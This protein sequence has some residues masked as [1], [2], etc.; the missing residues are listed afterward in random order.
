MENNYVIFLVNLLQD[1]NILRPLV[2]MAAHDLRLRTEFMVNRQ[3]LKRD[4]TLSWQRELE[5]MRAETGTSIL[6]VENEM[7]TLA[8][9]QGKAGALIAASESNL[10][11]HS[12]THDIFR[13]AP[14]SFL[15]ITLQHGFECVGFL[16]SKEHTLSYGLDVTF[17]ADVVCS[18]VDR[19][20]LISMTPSQLP[21]VYVTGS[22]GVLQMHKSAGILQNIKKTG[23]V[24]E[25]LH[26][27]R[28]N[29]GGDFKTGFMEIFRDYCATLAGEGQLVT[30]RPHPGGQ[31]MLKSNFELPPNVILNNNPVYKVDLSGYAYGI[32]APSS[33]LIDMVLAGIPVAVWADE[34]GVM[35]T[36]NYRGLTKISTLADWIAFSHDAVSNPGKYLSLQT[37]FLENLRMVTNPE[38]T[39]RQFARL[40]LATSR[41]TRTPDSSIFTPSDRI[42]FIANGMDP[43]LQLCLLNP[44]ESEMESGKL[45][46]SIITGE[47]IST[48]FGT[49]YLDETVQQWID[50]RIS[51]F[52]PTIVVFCR[53]NGRHADYMVNIARRQGMPVIYHL[54]DDLL[55]VP[56]HLGEKKYLKHNDPQRL[57]TV[58]FLLDKSDLVYCSTI[59]LK[60]HFQ[61]AG[62]MTPLVGGLINCAGSIIVPAAERKARRI[63]YMGFDKVHEL[64]RILPAIVKFLRQNPEVEFELFGTFT[65]PPLLE[66]FG[67]RIHLFKPVRDYKQFLA[68]LASHE[69]DIGI[70]PLEVTPFNLK[71]SNNKW[72]EYTSVGIAVIASRSTVYDDCCADGCGVLVDSIDEWESALDS[73]TNNSKVR[74]NMVKRAQ[75][76][77]VLEYST[78]RLRD[79]ILDVIETAKIQYRLDITSIGK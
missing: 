37:H 66:E 45:A 42:L 56:L 71:K 44:L 20:S 3:F 40:L 62:V 15:K 1:V 25:N 41:L 35:D 69:W 49:D 13:Y 54:D 9:L 39:Y 29:T 10:P 47:Q 22:T 64:E 74:F 75:E 58:R 12:A 26:S 6:V 61:A 36:D 68:E 50:R 55:N 51:L 32:S 43:T 52:R 57:A 30:L 21:K 48:E 59:K 5:Q 31:Y 53:Y 46:V 27:V 33:V 14:P 63:G 8:L 65:I 24:C 60:E 11:S 76:K 73:M 28:L 79:Q 34:T 23:L 78:G 70:C 38:E 72:V 67:E 2:Y 18:W 7:D 17:A 16:Q 4:V 77:L 19:A